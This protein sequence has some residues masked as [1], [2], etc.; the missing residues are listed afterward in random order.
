MNSYQVRFWA[1]QN[2]PG[3]K[4]TGTVSAGTQAAGTLQVFRH[5]G[6]GRRLPHHP[7][8]RRPPRHAVRPGQLAGRVNYAAH[9]GGDARQDQQ[10]E[11]GEEDGK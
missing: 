7:Q 5:L 11:R 8:R 4:R 10:R 3:K 1:I 6:P 2:L 9:D